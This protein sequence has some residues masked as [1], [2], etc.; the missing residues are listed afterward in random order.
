ML[1]QLHAVVQRTPDTTLQASSHEM[2]LLYG[3]LCL[4]SKPSIE[5]GMGS[6]TRHPALFGIVPLL[7]A[8]CF[9]GH[10]IGMKGL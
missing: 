9:T 4:Q 1:V 7:K 2:G 3:F 6:T 8:A 5:H 10:V